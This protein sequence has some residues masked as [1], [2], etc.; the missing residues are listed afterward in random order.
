MNS[1]HT[2]KSEHKQISEI[3]LTGS[4][5]TIAY[6]FRKVYTVIFVY[7]SVKQKMLNT[8][9]YNPVRIGVSH[10][11][12]KAEDK[13]LVDHSYKYSCNASI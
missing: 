8:T 1:S 6:R 12:C 4:R 9:L 7:E 11:L 2:S 5:K 13:L 10:S 3:L